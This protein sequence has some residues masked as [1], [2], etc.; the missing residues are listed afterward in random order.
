MHVDDHLSDLGPVVALDAAEDLELGLL[1]V[2][3]EEIDAL[4][5][6]IAHHSGQGLHLTDHALRA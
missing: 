2:D 6:V 3:L 1:S 4:D 5:A